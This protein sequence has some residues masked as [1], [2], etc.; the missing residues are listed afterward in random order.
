MVRPW[1]PGRRGTRLLRRR[2]PRILLRGLGGELR[3]GRRWYVP[4]DLDRLARGW[5]EV[6]DQVLRL[7][8]RFRVTGPGAEDRPGRP[9]LEVARPCQHLQRIDLLWRFHGRQ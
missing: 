7:D 6:V 2:C 1:R 4:L 5:S 3:G 9:P 8:G